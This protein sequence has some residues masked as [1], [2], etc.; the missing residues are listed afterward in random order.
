MHISI[1]SQLIIR[2]LRHAIADLSL[3]KLQ[4]YEVYIYTHTH[5]QTYTFT[6]THIEIH[7]HKIGL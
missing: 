2:L 4:N 1:N 3:K 7:T 6:P 5:T